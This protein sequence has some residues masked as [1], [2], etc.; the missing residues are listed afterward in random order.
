MKTRNQTRKLFV[1]ALEDRAVPSASW[2]FATATGTL[3]FTQDAVETHSVSYEDTTGRGDVIAK[4]DGVTA[5]AVSGVKA[6]DL[7]TPGGDAFGVKLDDSLYVPQTWTANLGTGSTLFLNF[8]DGVWSDVA[9]NIGITEGGGCT[10]RTVFGAYE[11][12]GSSI[13][14]A[15]TVNGDGTNFNVF[16]FTGSIGGTV[17]ATYTDTAPSGTGHTFVEGVNLM[18]GTGSFVSQANGNHAGGDAIY[19]SIFDLSDGRLAGISATVFHAAGSTVGTY[20]PVDVFTY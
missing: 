8:R 2:T 15:C 19:A 1:E 5:L 17:N 10:S 4:I 9:L 7:E 3:T 18:G 11:L 16:S 20:G 13:T 12:A 14:Y 6:V